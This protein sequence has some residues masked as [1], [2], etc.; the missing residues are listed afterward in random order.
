MLHRALSC[1]QGRPEVEIPNVEKQ[2]YLSIDI[3]RFDSPFSL[4]ASTEKMLEA[5]LS[6]LLYAHA[7][8]AL[9]SRSDYILTISERKENHVLEC[10]VGITADAVGRFQ[11]G[12]LLLELTIRRSSDGKQLG[13]TLLKGPLC[14]PKELSGRAAEQY[15]S[16]LLVD[17]EHKIGNLLQTIFSGCLF[18]SR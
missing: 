1:N 9:Y 4:D 18:Q 2:Q 14:I 11:P 17:Q 16:E 3:V 13:S 15:L 5:L 10:D 12:S 6:S 7:G 8:R